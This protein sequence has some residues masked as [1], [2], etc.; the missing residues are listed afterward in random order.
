MGQRHFD[1]N[2]PNLCLVIDDTLG[3]FRRLGYKPQEIYI[4]GSNAEGMRS[5]YYSSILMY[6][7][8]AQK[9]IREVGKR[10]SDLDIIVKTDKLV[11]EEPD[12]DGFLNDRS[13][14]KPEDYHNEEF[15]RTQINVWYTQELI[16]VS[17]WVR[18]YPSF[19]M[20][21]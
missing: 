4:V 9:L 14:V 10:G 6:V 12:I 2:V 13:D 20:C 7:D 1:N 3:F 11:T 5:E 8:D 18:V 17:D 21:D 19:K 16:S 15:R